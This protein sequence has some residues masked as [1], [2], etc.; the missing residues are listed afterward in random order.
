MSESEA[1]PQPEPRRPVPSGRIER[2][3]EKARQ[4]RIILG[5]RG[6]WVWAAGM[7]LAILFGLVFSILGF[8]A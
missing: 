1:P 5:P 6:R 7:V 4:G 2:T 3:A 8:L